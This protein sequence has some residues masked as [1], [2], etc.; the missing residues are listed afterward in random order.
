MESEEG[1]WRSGADGKGVAAATRAEDCQDRAGDLL[2]GCAWKNRVVFAVC[3]TYLGACE[4]RLGERGRG[5]SLGFQSPPSS[6]NTCP[7]IVD[8]H[9]NIYVGMASYGPLSHGLL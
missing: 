7:D 5:R 4:H 2:R 6:K 1:E 9:S 8:G 3:T